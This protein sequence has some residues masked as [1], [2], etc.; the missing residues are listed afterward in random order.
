MS[1]NERHGQRKPATKF[2]NIRK[3]MEKQ[4]PRIV[5]KGKK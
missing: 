1:K 2:A 3:K 4:K 5:K